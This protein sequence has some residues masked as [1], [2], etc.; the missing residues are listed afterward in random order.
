MKRQ[1]LTTT[2]IEALRAGAMGDPQTPGLSIERL[3][4]GKLA[5]Q[6]KRRIPTR[7]LERKPCALAGKIVSMSGGS[8]PAISIGAA[9]KWAAGLNEQVENGVDPR[10]AEAEAKAAKEAAEAAE[11][12]R[13]EAECNALTVAQA[14]E[15]YMSAV[16]AN[17]HKIAKGKCKPLKPRSIQDKI[18]L[19]TRNV[20]PIIATRRIDSIVADDLDR[21]I[22]RI[23]REGNRGKP[24]PV[25]ANR[26]IAELQVFWGWC[27]SRRGR[28]AGVELTANPAAQLGE[29]RNP[30]GDRDRWLDQIELP[31]FLRALAQEPEPHHRRALLLL[32]LTGCRRSEV[33]EAPLDE[34]RGNLWVL[35]G[36]RTKNGREHPVMLGEWGVALFRQTNS[37]WVIA[38]PKI[39]GP[40]LSG[41]PKVLERIRVRMEKIGGSP[42]LHF[43]LHD[44]RRTM[45]SHIEEH[46]VSD[47]LA[48]LMLNHTLPGL[49]G[50][51]QRN[52]RA[53]AMA[54][55]FARWENA[56][57]AMAVEAE[58]GDAL[59]VPQIITKEADSQAKPPLPTV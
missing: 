49:A 57:I 8:Y 46:G 38:S 23:T 35:P 15:L 4:S 47:A 28:L 29:L 16:R 17:T 55:G 18:D 24:A 3:K 13:V 39:D 22:D 30:A 52:R 36:S 40:M 50:R 44:L 32:L 11:R 2:A 20:A 7:D 12:K 34:L 56:V 6:Y 1:N 26:T 5:W 14:H 54:D 31:L 27:C 33:L 37:E 53:A 45:R 19:Y 43:T 21:I 58:V 42:V 9:R 10:I 51:Y 41:W 25:Q 59:G 48:E